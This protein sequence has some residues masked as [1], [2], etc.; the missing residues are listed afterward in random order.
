MFAC[1]GLSSSHNRA[2]LDRK[3]GARCLVGLHVPSQNSPTL[4]DKWSC[5]Q[6]ISAHTL[7]CFH[8]QTVMNYHNQFSLLPPGCFIAAFICSLSMSFC[9]FNTGFFCLSLIMFALPT[10]DSLFSLKLWACPYLLIDNF[11]TKLFT[12]VGLSS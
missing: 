7:V 5:Q 1:E 12:K 4:K 10:S 3:A 8:I 6:V 2:L 11:W 9:D